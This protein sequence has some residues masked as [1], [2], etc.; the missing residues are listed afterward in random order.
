M[1]VN[2][3]LNIYICF[4]FKNQFSKDIPQIYYIVFSSTLYSKD[5]K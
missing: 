4:D 3:N 2:L 1:Q 5:I